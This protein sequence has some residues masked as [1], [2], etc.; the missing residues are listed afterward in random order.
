[1]DTGDLWLVAWEVSIRAA[2]EAAMHV[3]KRDVGA[4]VFPSALPER[5]AISKIA[6][7]VMF[8]MF[9]SALPRAPCDIGSGPGR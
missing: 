4:D 8:T 7:S 9:Q 1:M 3:G 2:R 6:S 5:A